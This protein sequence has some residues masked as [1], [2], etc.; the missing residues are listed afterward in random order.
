[1]VILLFCCYLHIRHIQSTSTCTLTKTLYPISSSTCPISIRFGSYFRAAKRSMS[2]IVRVQKL[3]DEKLP[4]YS[5]SEVKGVGFNGE[6]TR[7][8]KIKYQETNGEESAVDSPQTAVNGNQKRGLDVPYIYF[9]ERIFH[10]GTFL[11]CPC[12]NA[13]EVV[14]QEMQQKGE[15]S[16]REIM[17]FGQK[18]RGGL[19]VGVCADFTSIIEKWLAKGYKR[20]PE[21]RPTI[22]I[23]CLEVNK[24]VRFG[25][26]R[27][28]K[29]K[30]CFN[31]VVYEVARQDDGNKNDKGDLVFMLARL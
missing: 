15:S 5:D 7:D 4:Y 31:I 23:E 29:F 21:N 11:P 26:T 20:K 22:K 10:P 2:W 3:I 14:Q 17:S 30:F 18:T 6:V 24:L 28:R 19:L 9:Q 16:R 8:E 27:C 12:G 13:P 25:C 1:I